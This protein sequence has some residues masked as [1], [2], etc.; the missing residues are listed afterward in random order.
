[1]KAVHVCCSFL[2]RANQT[3]STSLWK[4]MTSNYTVPG[5]QFFFIFVST[6]ST[7]CQP[8]F[9]K[10]IHGWIKTY[11]CQASPRFIVSIWSDLKPKN[12][13]PCGLHSDHRDCLYCYLIC[14]DLHG[15]KK[16]KL[17]C[18]CEIYILYIAY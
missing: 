6:A 4:Q 5:I 16:N 3:Q 9:D 8:F 2:V 18:H 14:I 15:A 7:D 11:L 13:Y 12:S 10:K 17:F 1:M